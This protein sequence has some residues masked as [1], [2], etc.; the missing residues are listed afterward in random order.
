LIEDVKF[1]DRLNEV[2]KAT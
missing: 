1:E 2:D